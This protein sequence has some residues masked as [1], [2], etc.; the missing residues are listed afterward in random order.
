[1]KKTK[2]AVSKKEWRIDKED[3]I[4]TFV[5][6]ISKNPKRLKTFKKHITD[7]YNKTKDTA[8]FLHNLQILAMAEN[9]IPVL[10][11]RKKVSICELSKESNPSFNSV[12]SIA[13]DL[14]I[15]N[16]WY[17]QA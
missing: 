7:E 11:K 9:K 4:T 12:I 13:S 1:M 17:A 2:E 5:S 15:N 6:I 8:L 10:S 16:K 3:Y 14:G